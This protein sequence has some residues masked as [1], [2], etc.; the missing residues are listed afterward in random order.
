MQTEIELAGIFKRPC[1]Y[2]KDDMPFYPWLVPEPVVNF[3]LKY[4]E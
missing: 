1:R 3:D 4:K 2:F